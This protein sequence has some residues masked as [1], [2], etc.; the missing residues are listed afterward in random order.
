VAWGAFIKSA[1]EMRTTGT[2]DSL[3]DAVSFNELNKIFDV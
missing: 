2:F 1:Q 3:A